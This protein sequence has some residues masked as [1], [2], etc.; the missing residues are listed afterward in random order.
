VLA[1]GLATVS[2]SDVRLLLTVALC[3]LAGMA[4]YV[5]AVMLLRVPGADQALDVVRRRLPGRGRRS[6]ST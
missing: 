2:A 4:V 3:V 5:A 6:A 1:V